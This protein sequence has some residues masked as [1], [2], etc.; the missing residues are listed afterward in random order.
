MILLPLT[1]CIGA[2]ETIEPCQQVV[3]NTVDDL[4]MFDAVSLVCGP[5]KLLTPDIV[6]AQPR[7]AATF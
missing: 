4:P 2:F 7:E 1:G 3:D 5:Q 6:P